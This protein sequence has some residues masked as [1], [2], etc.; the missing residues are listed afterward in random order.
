MKKKKLGILIPI[1]IVPCINIFFIFFTKNSFFIILSAITGG[2]S[3][4]SASSV[5][6]INCF[7]LERYK[8]YNTLQ[9]IVIPISMIC[10]VL[11]TMYEERG[12]ELIPI[13]LLF[14]ISIGTIIIMCWLIILSDEEVE[15]LKK[16][17]DEINRLIKSSNS[18]SKKVNN[19]EY[20]IKGKE[21]KKWKN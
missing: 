16:E 12:V 19:T 4:T 3:L 10:Y 2:L 13:W 6:T 21:D 9:I 5:C 11:C 20:N 7:D 1:F 17:N 14:I 18:P 15:N 8:K